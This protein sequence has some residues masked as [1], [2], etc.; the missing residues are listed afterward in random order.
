MT[1]LRRC[2]FCG[3]KALV[4][5]AVDYDDDIYSEI[6]VVEC[7]DCGASSNGYDTEKEAIEHW[8][9]RVVAE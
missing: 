9:K 4:D 3:G 7:V 2:P 5:S 6:F 8:N 1:E